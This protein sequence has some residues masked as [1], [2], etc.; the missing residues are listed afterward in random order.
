MIKYIFSTVGGSASTYLI[1]N[2]SKK[3]VV[4]DKPDAIFQPILKPLNINPGTFKKRSKGF[5]LNN[6]EDLKTIFPKYIEYIKEMPNMTA[7]FNYAAELHL[8]SQYKVENVVFQVRH[9]LHSY[10]SFTKPERH[11]GKVDFYGG[12]ASIEAI[13]YYCKRWNALVEEYCRLM[14]LGICTW[15]LRYEFMD[16]DIN[17]L[18]DLK[19][20]YDSFDSSKRNNGVLD[21][22]SEHALKNMVSDT[23][24]KIYDE[25]KI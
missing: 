10:L 3:Y 7:V 9:P 22:A 2:L 1:D 19:W 6:S 11:K 14:E 17:Q 16:N 18:N 21:Q 13:N 4:G 8:F 15:I 24:F 20:V 25:W 23:Y 12:V 5:C